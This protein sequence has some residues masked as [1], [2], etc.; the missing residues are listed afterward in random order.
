M[1]NETVGRCTWVSSLTCL[2]CSGL[3]STRGAVNHHMAPLWTQAS[4]QSWQWGCGCSSLV[5]QNLRGSGGCF[6]WV[7]LVYVSWGHHCKHMLAELAPVPLWCEENQVLSLTSFW[8]CCLVTVTQLHISCPGHMAYWLCKSI[9]LFSS[10]SYSAQ[11][12][13]SRGRIYKLCIAMD[14]AN[15]QFRLLFCSIFSP[16]NWDVW[17]AHMHVLSPLHCFWTPPLS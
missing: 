12:S 13:A 16:W 1:A 8:P 17:T 9:Y 14:V 15:K 2:S 11:P 5:N 3:N 7:V 10:W 6:S 4:W